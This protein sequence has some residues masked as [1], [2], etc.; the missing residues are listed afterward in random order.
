MALGSIAT[1]DRGM[2]NESEVKCSVEVEGVGKPGKLV[3]SLKY[4]SLQV[5]WRQCG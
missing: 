2:D 5:L 4:V 1:C 3:Q